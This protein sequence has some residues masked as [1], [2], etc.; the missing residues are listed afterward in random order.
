PA[1]Y[2]VQR[3]LS[4]AMRDEANKAGDIDR[5]QA[6]AGQSA[7]LSRAVPADQLVTEIWEQA[8]QLLGRVP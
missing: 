7:R 1:P 8:E 4:Q 5:M 2:P 3:A 6:W